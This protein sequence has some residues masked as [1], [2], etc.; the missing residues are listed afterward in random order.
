VGRSDLPPLSKEEVLAIAGHVN[1]FWRLLSPAHRQLP[2]FRAIAGAVAA[3]VSSVLAAVLTEID[4][5]GV[6][7]CQEI[8][9]RNGRG[10]TRR[11]PSRR[12]LARMGRC[13]CT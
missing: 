3:G 6:Y 2:H 11:R 8:L 10:Q 5:C 7:S 1:E 4:L 9:R 12:G 13:L